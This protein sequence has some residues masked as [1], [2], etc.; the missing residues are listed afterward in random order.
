MWLFCQSALLTWS[1]SCH[2]WDTTIWMSDKIQ[3]NKCCVMCFLMWKV[4][5]NMNTLPSTTTLVWNCPKKVFSNISSCGVWGWDPG[6]HLRTEPPLLLLQ[7][8]TAVHNSNASRKY[9]IQWSDDSVLMMVYDT[10]NYWGSGLCPSPRI[11]KTRK[12]VL[13]TGSVSVLRRWEEEPTLLGPLER[14]K[15]NH[16]FL[17]YPTE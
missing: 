5:K 8:A 10:E 4:W 7:W 2:L 9:L 12:H 13:E 17:R 6:H 11:L 15:L 14:A 16:L 3:I 1:H